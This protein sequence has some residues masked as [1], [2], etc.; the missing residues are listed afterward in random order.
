MKRSK[1]NLRRLSAAGA[2]CSDRVVRRGVFSGK[3]SEAID[4]PPA[5]V[6]KQMLNTAGS[7][8]AQGDIGT[9]TTVY[10]SDAREC[11]HL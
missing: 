1:R 6:E 2:C 7:T 8:A 10:L 9:Q 4:P 5:Q 3:Q 11:W